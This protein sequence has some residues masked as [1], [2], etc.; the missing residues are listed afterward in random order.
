MF[1][2][3]SEGPGAKPA[4]PETDPAS[5]PGTNPTI[6]DPFQRHD[7]YFFKDGSITFLVR[8]ALFFLLV[9]YILPDSLTRLQV[10]GTLYCVHRY[11]FSRDSAYFSSKFSQLDIRDHEPLRTVVSLGDTERND[12]DAFLSILYPE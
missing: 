10:D 6:E 8:G 1:Q 12:F 5:L 3:A 2:A 4:S 9:L 11:F 7:K